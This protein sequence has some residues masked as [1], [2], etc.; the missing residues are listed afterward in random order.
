MVDAVRD[1]EEHEVAIELFRL[2][3]SEHVRM[4]LGETGHE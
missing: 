4:H 2:L 1:V 3:R